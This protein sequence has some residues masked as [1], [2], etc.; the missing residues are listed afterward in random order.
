M[1]VLAFIYLI[2]IGGILLHSLSEYPLI[3][4]PTDSAMSVIEDQF[5]RKDLSTPEKAS[6]DFYANVIKR[7]Q[8]GLFKSWNRTYSSLFYLFIATLIVNLIHLG[9]IGRNAYNK[10]MSSSGQK[11]ETNEGGLEKRPPSRL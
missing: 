1:K 8:R 5:L 2:V 7:N 6:Y 9:C 3:K 11:I 10:V 4:I